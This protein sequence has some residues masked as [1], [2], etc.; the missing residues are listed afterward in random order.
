[1]DKNIL[2]DPAVQAFI[3]S[4]LNDD[5]AELMLQRDKYPDWPFKEVVEQIVSRRKAEKKLP[6]WYNTPGIIFPSPVSVEQSSSEIAA[7]YKAHLFK[8]HKVVDLTGG[9]GV[10][11]YFL[12]QNFDELVYVEKDENLASI[13]SHNFDVLRQNNIEIVNATAEQYIGDSSETF[14]LV[15]ID[16]DRRP[17]KKRVTGFSDSAPDVVRLLPSL[18]VLS[19]NIL[20]KASP[21]MDIH[22]SIRQLGDVKN[23]FLFAMNN[24]LKEILF[25]LQKGADSTTVRCINLTEDREESLEYEYGINVQ[26]EIEFSILSDYLYEPNV[27]IMKAGAFPTLAK[28]YR[29]KKLHR[30]TNL[31]TS[32]QLIEE[33]PGRK[34]RVLDVAN[35]KKGDVQ[36]IIGGNK[37][38]VS[39]R[40]FIDTP[41]QVKKK[42]GLKDGGD[43]Y[44][45]GFK[46]LENKYKIAICEKC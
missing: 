43:Q 24:E 5:P 8:G 15:Y 26:K 27:S 20:I 18:K 2:L 22:D 17:D 44:L 41:D 3:N 16:P 45:F 33:F 7:E 1:M 25:L 21:M 14:D 39:V 12:A 10:D 23:I 4:H 31:F 35:Y 13:A 42:L 38:N 28:Q 40:N 11:S 30:D 34:F 19:N 6:T 46:D 29:V 36:Q 9:L 37:V 32:D